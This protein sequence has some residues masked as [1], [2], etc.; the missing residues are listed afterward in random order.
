MRSAR[1]CGSG[2][3]AAGR[4]G[5]TRPRANT[6]PNQPDRM[7]R[8]PGGRAHGFPGALGDLLWVTSLARSAEHQR[9]L[10]RL[11]YPAVLP[12]SHCAGWAAD[13]EM[14]WFRRFGADQILRS[15]LL[16]RQRAGVVN[17]ID[18]GQAWHMCVSPAVAGA[19]WDGF[20]A[21][22]AG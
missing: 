14:S 16:E 11:G 15:L 9:R 21:E 20:D 7:P 6:G 19:L 3:N 18:E 17:V 13:I 4:D 1:T 2:A 8:H 22:M 12:S 5:V 10:R